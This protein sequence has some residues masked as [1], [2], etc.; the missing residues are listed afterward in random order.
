MAG[1]RFDSSTEVNRIGFQ[2]I[3]KMLQNRHILIHNRGVVD[4]NY[5]DRGGD[6]Q[7]QLG[8]RIRI[9]S[10]E[11]KRFVNLVRTMGANLMDNVENQDFLRGGS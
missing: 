3:S 1:G 9:R 10:N 7:F 5:L 4:Q 11:A 6:Q 8:E 2:F